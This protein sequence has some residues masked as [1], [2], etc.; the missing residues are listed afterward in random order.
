MW[1]SVLFSRCTYTNGRFLETLQTHAAR[2][3]ANKA[4]AGTPSTIH[5]MFHD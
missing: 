4:S 1:L 5:R 2:E 3:I